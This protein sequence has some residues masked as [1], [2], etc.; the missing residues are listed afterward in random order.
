MI[1]VEQLKKILESE[2]L[3][4]ELSGLNA[5]DQREALASLLNFLIFTEE[6]D[7]MYSYLNHKK[8]YLPIQYLSEK[9]KLEK[10]QVHALLYHKFFKD[11]YLYHVTNSCYLESILEKGLEPITVRYKRNPYLECRDFN[12][13]WN[14]ILKKNQ[15]EPRDVISIPFYSSIY[16]ERFDSVYLGTNLAYSLSCYGQSGGEWMH[17]FI[18]EWM[19]QLSSL[20]ENTFTKAEL[21]EWL[22]TTIKNKYSVSD[23]DMDFLLG[24]YDK[25]YS[26]KSKEK[27]FIL[28]PN[29]NRKI[30]DQNESY[31]FTYNKLKE[32]QENFPINYELCTDVEHHGTISP[33]GLI[34]VTIDE[35]AKMKVYT[36]KRQV[37]K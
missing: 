28:V 1:Q 4:I 20:Q 13:R 21:K 14:V 17:L 27:A 37:D 26:E 18:T 36:K 5:Q 25:Y 8:E 10:K 29:N 35:K 9:Y 22:C 31:A 12:S 24:F 2:E 30:N 23:I 16:K 15:Q 34:G 11:G 19:E 32:E 33:Q 6:Y 7:C 3:N